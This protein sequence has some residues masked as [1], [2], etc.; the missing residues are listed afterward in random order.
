MGN[1]GK[2]DAS[3]SVKVPL[4]SMSKPQTSLGPT[5]KFSACSYST[6]FP[7]PHRTPPHQRPIPRY[8][9]SS[10]ARVHSRAVGMADENHLHRV[11]GNLRLPTPNRGNGPLRTGC[12]L[13]ARVGGYGTSH[14][15]GV[16]RSCR[17]LLRSRPVDRPMIYY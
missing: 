12:G 7:P 2:T 11:D 6:S 17:L 10:G 9:L 5:V 13:N 1:R 4:S 3:L 16:G 15:G 8:S 14:D